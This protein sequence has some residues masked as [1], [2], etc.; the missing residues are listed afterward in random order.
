MRNGV[1]SV[2]KSLHITTCDEIIQKVGNLID[3]FDFE[4]NWFSKFGGGLIVDLI[5]DIFVED[6]SS[7]QVGT[8]DKSVETVMKTVWNKDFMIVG[9]TKGFRQGTV[10]TEIENGRE[11]ESIFI[12]HCCI[13]WA[14]SVNEIDKCFV[15][16]FI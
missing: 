5:V 10:D 4:V 3:W 7:G 16:T 13:V 9:D 8:S 1:T 2:Q 6:E 11:N 14:D 15:N 12:G